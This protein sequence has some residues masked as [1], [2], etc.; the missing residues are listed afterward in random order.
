MPTPQP[1]V[2]RLALI[3][4]TPLAVGPVN[5]AFMRLWPDA[6][7][8]NLLDDSL[9]ADL[10]REGRLTDAMRQRFESLALYARDC[11]CDGILFTCSAFGPA[12]EAAGRACGLP[13]LKPN[14]AMFEQAVAAG[15]RCALVATFEPSIA[16]MRDEFEALCRAAGRPGALQTCVVPGAMQALADGDAAAHDVAIAR[17]V[18]GIAD[19]DL[20]MLA[21]FSMAA[22]APAAQAATRARVL[23]SP[24]CAVLAM[25]QA[26]GHPPT[27]QP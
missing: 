2:A 10:A 20:V 19:V 15:G 8:M 18:A 26:L 5:Q 17:G 24:D 3:H 16:P 14:Q 21:Q 13:T 25:R 23:T 12:I 9:S 22:A 11:G 1:A 6:T 27:V 7:R 4:A